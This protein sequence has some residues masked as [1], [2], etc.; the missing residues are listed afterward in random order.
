MLIFISIF[1][2][3]FPSIRRDHGRCEV[4]RVDGV[5]NLTCATRKEQDCSFHSADAC[6]VSRTSN[7][8][9]FSWRGMVSG[10]WQCAFFTVLERVVAK[11]IAR[12]F[13]F[14]FFV[15]Y[16]GDLYKQ[17]IRFQVSRHVE[18]HV[19]VE[20]FMY[21]VCHKPGYLLMVRNIWN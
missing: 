20:N 7:G 15:R 21:G 8:S 18:R 17:L 4:G 6:C 1:A 13:L 19:V 5:T 2:V 16:V 11:A 10:R 14:F 3:E 9:L 12:T